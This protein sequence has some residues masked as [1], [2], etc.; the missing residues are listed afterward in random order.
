MKKFLLLIVLLLPLTASAA[1]PAKRVSRSEV[2]SIVSDFRRYE[3]VEVVKMG[4]L[5]TA[6]FKGLARHMDDQ[7]AD[8]QMLRKL[9]RGLRNVTVLE[10][11]GADPDVRARLDRRIARALGR[12]ELLME[13]RD[14]GTGM[15]LF[16]IVDD[17]T[18]MVH[19]LVM[20]APDD[21]TLICL[22]GSI[23]MDAVGQLMAE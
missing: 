23:P 18:G 2:A 5:G 20:R 22:F 19:D 14:G 3:G 6:L 13:A 4:W 21:C 11:E 8:M 7:D 17:A 15:Q 9:L 16:G 12:S 10:Y 1:R